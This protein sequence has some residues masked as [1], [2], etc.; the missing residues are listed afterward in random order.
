M[1]LLID[2]NLSPLR[3]SFLAGEGVDAIHWSI[4]GQPNAA[5]AETLDFAAANAW[6]VF[7]SDLDFG[8][9]LTTLQTNK[10]SAL[11]IRSQDVLQPQS[12]IVLRAIRTAE[13]H[14]EARRPRHRGLLPPS[15]STVAYLI[16]ENTSRLDRSESCTT[17]LC[18]SIPQ[19]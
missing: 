10:P 12:D 5:D 3:V 17:D 13:P 19:S 9:L 7:T 6:I 14:L 4:V 15:R 18:R 8:T 2:M 16:N 1:K 11:Q